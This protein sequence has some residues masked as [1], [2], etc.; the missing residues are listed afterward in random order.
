MTNSDT[1]V[2]DLGEA[3]RAGRTPREH[4]PYRIQLGDERL[5]FRPVV[6]ADPVP[7]GL[8]LLEA[9]G[10]LPIAEHLVFQILANGLL[11][12]LRPDETTDLRTAG[13]EKFVVFRS[14]RS[15]RFILDDRNFEWGAERILGGVLQK[16]AGVDPSTHAVYQ[17]RPGSQD[18]LIGESE[19][20]NLQPA[21]VERFHTQSIGVTIVVEGTPH[22][23]TKETITYAQVVTLE[24]PDYAQHPEI[25]YSVKY[26]NG[27]S[28][29]PEGVLSPNGSVLFCA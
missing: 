28:Q 6:I 25:T 11:E 13:V 15:F 24:V 1:S 4:G 22:G 16:L 21:G 19:Y 29:N 8:Q 17:D 9:A 26:K 5:H 27:P 2:E 18:K 12:G 10:A 23:W 3:L 14:D 7:T 20:A